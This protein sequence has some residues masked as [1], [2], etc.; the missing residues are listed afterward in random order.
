M[1]VFIWSPYWQGDRL[2]CFTKHNRGCYT[3]FQHTG[4]PISL[5][6]HYII[7]ITQIHWRFMGFSWLQWQPTN[8]MTNS[9]AMLCLSSPQLVTATS[10]A[11]G[12]VKQIHTDAFLSSR[13][14]QQQLCVFST[15][16]IVLRNSCRHKWSA[17]YACPKS[18][19]IYISGKSLYLYKC[20]K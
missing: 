13:K 19:G 1:E 8:K 16:N 4:R 15:E 12:K 14:L 18:K 6:Q 11:L 10:K 2:K 5:T 9:Y 17:S 3:L 7:Y 20:Y